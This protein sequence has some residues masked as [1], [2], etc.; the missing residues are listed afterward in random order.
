MFT[1]Y[2]GQVFSSEICEIFKNTFE[3]R[4]TSEQKQEETLGQTQEM[5][6]ETGETLCETW[7][8]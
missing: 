8:T 1:S 4:K 6:E 3:N 7:A 5:P 2:P